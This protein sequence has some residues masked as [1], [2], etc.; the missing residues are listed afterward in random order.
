MITNRVDV[1]QVLM[2]MRQM[3]AQVQTQQQT[4]MADV[5][6]PNAMN[7]IKAVEK[8]AQTDKTGFASMLNS[9]VNQVNDLG[10]TSG[11]LAKD[12]TLGD[13][14]VSITQVMVASQK[15]SVATEALVQVRNKLV[16]AY[17]EIRKMPV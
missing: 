10:H 14:K 12:Y 16:N 8:A 5:A 4:P 17:E 11:K 3:K 2:Q 6:K 7:T 13:P 15:S 9:A 1:N